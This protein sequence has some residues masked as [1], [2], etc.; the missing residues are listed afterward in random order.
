MF[1]IESLKVLIYL[2]PGLIAS[3]IYS[4]LTV[5]TVSIKGITILIES[6]LFSVFI[7]MAAS[8][9]PKISPFNIDQTAGK[10][11]P[12]VHSFAAVVLISVFLAIA[13]AVIKNKDI[14]FRI[15]RRLGITKNT[16]NPSI[17]NEVFSKYDTNI[18][19]NFAD[20]TRLY[21]HP[22]YYSDNQNE[23]Y[24]FLENP[25]WV[26]QNKKTKKEEFFAIGNLQGILITPE[27][28]IESIEFYPK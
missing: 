22:L 26:I 17:W 23:Q 5:R 10:I 16:S 25:N 13:M 24:I 1:T 27:Y 15:L 2:T 19:I 9:I 12:D 20:K 7:F 6:L 28:K 11:I 14:P 3:V 18:I 8:L 4:A 21:G